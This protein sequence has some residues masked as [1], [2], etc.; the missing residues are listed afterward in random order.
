MK[1]HIQ[2]HRFGQGAIFFCAILWSTSGLFIKLINWHPLLIAGGRSFFAALFLL[3]IRFLFP[4]K[5]GG[6][7]SQTLYVILGGTMY[8]ATMIC[9][10]WANKLTTS[11]NAILLQYSAPIWAAILGWLFVKEKP[12]WEHWFAL[13]LVIGGLL[14]FFRE[15]LGGGSFWGNCLAVLSGIF[16][17][18][19]S[20]VL[21]LQKEGNPMDSMI[22]AHIICA[23]VAIPFVFTAFP[24]VTGK[25]MIAIL[26]MGFI[27]I[28]LASFLFSYG[29][30]RINAI[31]AMLT[32]MIEP[33][34]NPLWVLVVTGEKP[35]PSA[36]LGGI[37]IVSAVLISSIIGKGRE[38]TAVPG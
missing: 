13:V 2:A 9:F 1:Y 33:V 26:F 12:H 30:K 10:V 18:A 11:A 24:A 15:G 6:I 5:K 28:G 22:T 35:S 25:N 16:F 21:R 8:A 3:T 36:L 29:I 4:P 31:Q 34:L 23:V 37:I 7:G 27:Q 17:G 32:A 14:L 38:K 20:V 19:H